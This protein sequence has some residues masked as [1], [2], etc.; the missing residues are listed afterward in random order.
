MKDLNPAPFSR[1]GGNPVPLKQNIRHSREG[2]NPVLL[3]QNVLL[4]NRFEKKV[5]V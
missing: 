4:Q 1:A 5:F 2:G 3:K